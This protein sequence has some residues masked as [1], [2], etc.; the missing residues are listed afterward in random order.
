MISDLQYL[1]DIGETKHP[2]GIRMLFKFPNGYQ[3]SCVQNEWS[4]GG[5]QEL[6]EVAAIN[7]KG[8]FFALEGQLDTVIGWLDDETAEGVVERIRKL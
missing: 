8:D 1:I 7:P 2:K 4:Y 5:D 6:W 3:A